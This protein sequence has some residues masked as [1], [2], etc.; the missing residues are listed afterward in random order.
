MIQK[1]FLGIDAGTQGLSVIFTDEAMKVVETGDGSYEM[2]AG[3]GEGCY[4]QNPG[5]WERAAGAAMEDLRR[6]LAKKGIEPNILAIGI[7]G[8]MHGEVLADDQG[9]PIGPARLWCDSRNEAEGNELTEAFGTKMPKRITAARWLWTT[10]NRSD[11]ARR[12]KRM[13][14]PGGW[15]AFRLTGQWNLGIGDA[16]GMFPIDQTTMNFDERLLDKFNSICGTA[17]S[18]L[19]S[20]LPSVRKA[21]EDGGQLNEAG[22]RLLGLPAG[23]PVAPAEGDQ[24]AALAGSLIGS[25]GMVSMSFGTSVCANSVGDRPFQGV[26]RS[27]DHFCA[28]DGRPINMVWLRNGTTF[29][30]TVVEMFGE[31]SG[32]DR[33]SAF[34]RVMPQ[35][36]S[37]PADCGG[38]LA[39]PFM[40][41]EPG[42]GISRGGSA[43][44][45]GLS[46]TN[47]N[48]GNAAKAAILAT[49]FNLRIG[50]EALDQQNFPRTEIILSGG[51]T[52]TPE[53]GQLLADVFNTPVKILDS[54]AE[55]SAWGASLLAKFRYLTINGTQD[56]WPTFLAAHNTGSATEFKPNAS[57]Y[58][59]LA[60]SLVRYR[61]LL[62][63]NI[64]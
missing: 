44:L 27:I 22:A 38:L 58:A 49:M 40:D 9:M 54:A 50:A 13:T 3:L 36:V 41:D 63:E 59:L 23:I 12:A 7:S 28:A 4:E 2:V 19:K 45:Y 48:A 31:G 51:L 57:N 47:A 29:M 35:V 62:A 61:K 64:A 52:K 18:S 17:V 8:Q 32:G 25:P 1:G 24:P 37:A 6:K 10:R 16:A 33:S 30:N 15:L 26:S 56:S 20:L 42:L 39:L 34:R 11:W 14:T 55:G 21:G 5:D 53:L 43:M 60:Q 46:S